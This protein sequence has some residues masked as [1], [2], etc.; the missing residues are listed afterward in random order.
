MVTAQITPRRKLRPPRAA[1]Q[2]SLIPKA[3]V[4]AHYLDLSEGKSGPSKNSSLCTPEHSLYLVA[5]TGKKCRTRNQGQ[6]Y[7]FRHN[8]Q[9]VRA[10]EQ[11][12]EVALA[13]AKISGTPVPP[14][15]VGSSGLTVDAVCYSSAKSKVSGALDASA[16]PVIR[17][18]TF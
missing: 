11:T 7:L 10:K 14:A 12:L 6:L 13:R 5:G 2:D 1:I 17:Y 18:D 3:S 8:G 9:F 16:I 4:E 15:D